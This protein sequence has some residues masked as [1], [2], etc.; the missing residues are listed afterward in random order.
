MATV[1][2]GTNGGTAW[3]RPATRA[4]RLRH[5][6]G[7]ELRSTT[8]PA[9][10]R[11]PPTRAASTRARLYD[12]LGRIDARRSRTTP[13]ARTDD[14][15]QRDDGIHLRRRQQ[16]ADREAVQPGGTPTQTT[17]YVYGVTTAGGSDI[18]SNDLL[19]AVEYPDPTHGPAQ[20]PARRRLHLSTPSARRMHVHRPQ[21]Q[22]RTRTPTTC[23][24]G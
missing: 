16:R 3:T 6:A 13:A 10:C 4:D 5:G 14:F 15:E 11:T 17:Q 21:R 12:A 19:A 20:Q 24:A 2:V 1:D 23:W 18:N 7:D 22:R 8:P 9:G